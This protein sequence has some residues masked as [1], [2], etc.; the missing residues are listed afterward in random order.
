MAGK[1]LWGQRAKID[2]SFYLR[3][4]SGDCKQIRDPKSNH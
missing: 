3:R 2:I 1:A 4:D